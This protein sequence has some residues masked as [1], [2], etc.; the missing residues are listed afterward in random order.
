SGRCVFSDRFELD[1]IRFE[2]PTVNFFSFNNPYGAC[3]TCEGFGKVLGIDEDL[4]IPDKSLSIYEGAIAPWKS[5]TMSAWLSPLLRNAAE[6]EFPIHRP[7][8]DLSEEQ[9]QLI[10]TGNKYFKGLNAFFAHLQ[11]KAQSEEHT[12]ELQSRENLVCRL[13]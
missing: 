13:L 7:Y 11:S 1:D 3:K 12:S 8:G 5:E 4:V 10:W 6:F 2:E 9:R